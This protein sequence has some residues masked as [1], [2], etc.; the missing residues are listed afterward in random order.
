MFSPLCNGNPETVVWCH[1]D[2]QEHGRGYGHKAH[3]LC[4]FYGC[5]GCNFWFDVESKRQELHE[6]RRH[7]FDMAH[8]RSMARVSEKL[9]A[10]ELKL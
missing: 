7:L 2:Y 5:S 3:D 8:G 9:E 4:G 6:Q 1:S 10:G